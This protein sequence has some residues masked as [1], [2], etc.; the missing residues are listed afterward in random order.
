MI[1]DSTKAELISAQIVSLRS[2]L[3]EYAK[4]VHQAIFGWLALA[5]AMVGALWNEQ[6]VPNQEIRAI[7]TFAGAQVQ[8]FLVL[9]VLAAAS[10]QMA[11]AG[12]IAALEI[13]MNQLCGERLAIWDSEVSP[14]FM[15]TIRSAFPLALTATTVLLIV[16]FVSLVVLARA[17]IRNDGLWMFVAVELLAIAVLVLRMFSEEARARN[18][19]LT[20]MRK[21]PPTG[22]QPSVPP[23]AV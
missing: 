20:E 18:F 5:G 17:S 15:F 14:N 7:L 1:E 6:V 2:E 8:L 4:V 9:I 23:D 11:H 3:V 16:N 22:E 13:R 10:N 19:A 12:A 21:S